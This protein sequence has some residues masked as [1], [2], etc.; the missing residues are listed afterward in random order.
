VPAHQALHGTAPPA[1]LPED[2]DDELGDVDEVEDVVVGNAGVDETAEEAV[3]E[4]TSPAPVAAVLEEDES[5][6]A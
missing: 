3:G 4:A 5:P 2:D 6:D 1:V